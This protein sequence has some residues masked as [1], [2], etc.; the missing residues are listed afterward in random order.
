[1]VKSQTATMS[2]VLYLGVSFATISYNIYL[3]STL[4]FLSWSS[5]G[6][7]IV[8]L[9]TAIYLHLHCLQTLKLLGVW[10]CICVWG[11]GSKCWCTY[12]SDGYL[13]G[14]GSASGSNSQYSFSLLEET[15]P[16]SP[17]WT[18][19]NFN[20]FCSRICSKTD[21]D[22]RLPEQKFS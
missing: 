6:V 3:L 21:V 7:S 5:F 17:P 11:W 16:D 2:N 19:A 15:L 12:M 20:L 13:M 1:M 18:W 4:F 14:L 22:Y 10:V 8:S 9:Y